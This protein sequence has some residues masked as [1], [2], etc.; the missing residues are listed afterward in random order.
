MSALTGAWGKDA[1]DISSFDEVRYPS[2]KGE[3]YKKAGTA[4]K[5][6]I[7]KFWTQYADQAAR[8]EEEENV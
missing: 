6:D 7:D 2:D 3:T 1:K 4:K 8:E 5:S